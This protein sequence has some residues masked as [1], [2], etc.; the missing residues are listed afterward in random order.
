MRLSG[1][2]QRAELLE[3]LYDRFAVI[4]S[5]EVFCMS[6]VSQWEKEKKKEKK[7][8]VLNYTFSVRC[9]SKF[10]PLTAE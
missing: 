7:T 2:F 8:I 9:F 4:Y 3:Y 5:L 1:L 10:V 6:K